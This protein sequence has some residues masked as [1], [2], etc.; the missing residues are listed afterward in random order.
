MGW[1]LTSQAKE[2]TA[3][4]SAMRAAADKL[5]GGQMGT[6]AVVRLTEVLEQQAEEKRQVLCCWVD[7]KC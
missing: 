3:R 5:P 4:L 1:R 2:I 7:T 6:D